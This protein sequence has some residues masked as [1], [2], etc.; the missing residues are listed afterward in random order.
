MVIFVVGVWEGISGYMG[1]CG[2]VGMW[3]IKVGS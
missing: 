3:E 2:C 1:V